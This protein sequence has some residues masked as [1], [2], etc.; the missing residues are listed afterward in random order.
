M[1]DLDEKQFI[2]KINNCYRRTINEGRPV[3][4]D[5]YNKD[6]AMGVLKKNGGSKNCYFWG[7]YEEAE[8]Q[9]IGVCEYSIEQYEFPIS[10]IKIKIDKH[11]TKPLAHRDYLGALLNLGIKREVIGDIMINEEGADIILRENMSDYI[12]HE[13]TS[14]SRYNQ[15]QISQV[16]VS[17]LKISM[18][19]TKEYQAVVASLRMDV[20][21]AVGFGLSRAESVKLIQ[22]S[23]VKC[24]GM[25][26]TNK[27][28]VKEGDSISARGHG[29]IKFNKIK[30]LTKKERL[31]ITIEKYV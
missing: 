12:S 25:D 14:V 27:Q 8:R 10:G 3:F 29:K 20:I 2:Q 30:G 21:V 11:K 5:F 31:Q 23:K 4:M 7:G 28:Q 9:M 1:S 19:I 13:L 17:E 24:N 22:S 26:V 16:N 6:W 15:I 18:P